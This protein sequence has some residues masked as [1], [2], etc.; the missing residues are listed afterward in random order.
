[1][2]SIQPINHLSLVQPTTGAR[3]AGVEAEPRPVSEDSVELSGN[4]QL[5]QLFQETEAADATSRANKV[6]QIKQSLNSGSYEPNLQTV[7]E[8]LL[9]DVGLGAA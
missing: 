9:A 8:R 3:R 4:A 7:A 1:M 5:K 6:Y 2:S